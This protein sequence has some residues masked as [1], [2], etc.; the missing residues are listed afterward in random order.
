MLLVSSKE[1]NEI[2]HILNCMSNVFILI[3]YFIV[4]ILDHVDHEDPPRDGCW[5]T[6]YHSTTKKTKI[7]TFKKKLY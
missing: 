1:E 3:I 4:Y 5:C 7:A 2:I 6:V